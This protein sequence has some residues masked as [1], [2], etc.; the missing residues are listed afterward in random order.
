MKIYES[1]TELIGN[2]PLVELKN[3]EKE[4]G[5]KARVLVKVEAFNPGG[6]AKD[7]IANAMIKKAEEQGVLKPGGTI[8]EPTSGNTGVGLAWIGASKGYK[9]ILTMPE[10]MSDERKKLL[11]ALGAELVLTRAKTG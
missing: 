1:M 10:T 11:K 7:R 8:I 9:V 3:I 5:L 6:S 2:T 4:K